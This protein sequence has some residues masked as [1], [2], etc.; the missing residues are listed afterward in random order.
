MQYSICF[1]RALAG[2]I[3]LSATTFSISSSWQQK[4]QNDEKTLTNVPKHPIEYSPEEYVAYRTDG[5]IAVDGN[6]TEKEWGQIPWTN[7]FRDIEGELKPAPLFQTRAKMA[8]DDENMYFAF[9]IKEPHIWGEIT[10]RDAVIFHDNDI[11]IFIDPDGDTHEYME[12]E[13]NALN[14]VWDLL[15]TKPYRD[16]K[17]R[18][19]DTWTIRGQKTAVKVYGTLNN[20]NDTDDKWTVEVAFPWDDISEAA[21]HSGA[22]LNGEQWKIGFSRVNWQ[23]DAENGEYKKKRNPETGKD[24]SEFNW[25]WSAQG[26]IAMHQ[27]E[28]WGIVQF[29]DQPAGKGPAPEIDT[30]VDRLKWAMRQIYYRQNA[31]NEEHGVY[32][33]SASQLKLD[34]VTAEGLEFAPTFTVFNNR[35]EAKQI[36][37]N[38]KSIFIRKDGKVWEE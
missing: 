11:E 27:P 18:V 26:R 7:G 10:D 19:L 34:D 33:G 36:S 3:L 31:F 16:P 35:W 22:P 23:V 29:A 37:Y 14:T 30:K 6:L 12:W 17:M 9:E 2:A 25:T 5:P 13:L 15:L 21:Q 20:P 24:Y 4:A 38:G 1:K 28:T 8:W 32:A